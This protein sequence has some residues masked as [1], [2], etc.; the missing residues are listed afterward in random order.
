MVLTIPKC[1][2]TIA[3]SH[4][5]IFLLTLDNIKYFKE[6]NMPTGP[7]IAAVRI[8]LLDPAKVMQSVQ[9]R[10]MRGPLAV[11]K[12]EAEKRG[13]A[14]ATGA[15]NAYG[16]RHV[17]VATKEI[18]PPKGETGAAVKETSVEIHV[19]SFTK[20]GSKDQAA[21]MVVTIQA[22]T[23]TETREMLLEAPGGN[24]ATPKEYVIVNNKVTPAK[25]WWTAFV[26]CLKSKCIA[27]CLSALLKCS[28]TWAAY[29]ACVLATCA[30][31]GTYCVACA[32]CNC[33]WWCKWAVGCC[34]Q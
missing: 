6:E 19:Q 3:K 23:N 1:E 7:N 24:F 11:L 5:N 9:S 18:K 14:A 33:K 34:K 30:A 21:L 20:K 2:S 13:Y 31:C 25:S 27:N 15:K 10:A 29:L 26:S 17:F 16:Y 28:G 12:N 4:I 32:T 8:E 22:G